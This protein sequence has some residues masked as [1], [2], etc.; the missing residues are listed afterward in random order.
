MDDLLCFL[1]GEDLFYLKRQDDLGCLTFWYDDVLE[2]FFH[3]LWRG[4][5]HGCK[6]IMR[7]KFIYFSPYLLFKYTTLQQFVRKRWDYDGPLKRIQSI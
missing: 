3:L 2:E 4:V 1:L 6:S 5:L 7:N